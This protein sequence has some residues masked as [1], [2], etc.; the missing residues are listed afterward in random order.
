MKRD[1]ETQ[2]ILFDLN[3]E[4]ECAEA[5]KSLY[6]ETEIGQRYV[7][8]FYDGD[9]GGKNQGKI[10]RAANTLFA[11]DDAHATLAQLARALG[12]LIRSGA[13]RPLEEEEEDKILEAPVVDTTPRGRDGQPLTGSQ[14]QWREYREWSEAH[15][16]SECKAKAHSDEAYGKFYRTNL[17]REFA[18]E[19][20]GDAVIP[21]GRVA[22]S[23]QATQ[24]LVQFVKDY[25]KEPVANLK[26]RA[27]FV[28]LAGEQLLWNLYQE[29]LGKA[30]AAGLL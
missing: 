10:L 22:R 18:A 3:D 29:M 11:L 5:F 15:T 4:Q 13:I 1:E 20:V 2:G 30:L 27:G 9:E 24:Q 12:T 25:H 23:T 16:S 19:Q 17:A 28:S 14:I 8:E 6:E 21:A 7:S 26:P